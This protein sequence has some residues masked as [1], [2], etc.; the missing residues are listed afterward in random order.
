[1]L[2]KT[3]QKDTIW[4]IV[5][6]LTKSTHF[7]P[8]SEK[9]SLKKLSKIYMEDIIRL[10]RVP[11]SNCIDRDPRLTSKF[12]DRMQKLYETT[13]KFSTAVHPRTNGQ[14]E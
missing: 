5:G 10:H 13:L 6:R 8:I 2:Q 9:D 7:I 14:T 1:V 11:T 3:G 4:I 12:W